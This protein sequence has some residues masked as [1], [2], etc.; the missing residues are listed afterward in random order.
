MTVEN[1]PPDT[2]AAAS[3]PAATRAEPVL[4][5]SWPWRRA[6]CSSRSKIPDAASGAATAAA[7]AAR[8]LVMY[9][10]INPGIRRFITARATT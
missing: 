7:T 5:P 8:S 9:R 4:P 3:G 6:H 2:S 10:V 1:A